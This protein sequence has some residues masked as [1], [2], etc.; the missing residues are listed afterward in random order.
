M[1]YITVINL[2]TRLIF[3]SFV[4]IIVKNKSDY[5]LVPLLNGFGIFVGGIIGLI[6]LFGKKGI[7]FKWPTWGILFIYVKNT[8][9]LFGSNAIISLKDRFNVIFIGSSLGMSEVALY[10]LSIKIMGLFMQPSEIIN[11][12]IY[13]K[14]AKE[15]NMRMLLQ[16]TKITFVFLLFAILAVQPFLPT[17]IDFLVP[18][19]H[20]ALIPV[21]LMLIAPLIMVWSLSIGR[22][23]LLV[24]GEYKTFTIG[25]ALTS[26]FYFM[27]IFLIYLLGLNQLL[28]SFVIITIMVYLF[29]MIYRIAMA[30]KLKLI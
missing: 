25:M 19:L 27:L 30:K 2:V 5:L 24:H 29:E 4:F 21:R 23:C 1:K 22:N 15:K 8:L 10:D 9:P 20:N 13:P 6:I 7:N 11:T 12:T 3:L 14:M 18:G 26:I 28:I 17:V 16:I